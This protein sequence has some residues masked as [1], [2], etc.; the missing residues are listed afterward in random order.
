MR[1]YFLLLDA[2]RF[3]REIVSALAASW[4]ARSFQ[5]THALCQTVLADIEA[6]GFDPTHLSPDETVAGQIVRHGIAFDRDVWRLL[7]GEVLL[8]CAAEIPEMETTPRALGC[9]LGVTEIPSDRSREQ[10]HWIEQV[11][12][13]S[14][15]ICLGGGFYRPEQAGYNDR[16]DVTRLASL[17]A[18][19]RMEAWRPEQLRALPDLETDDDRAEELAYVREWF[20]SLRELYEK[21]REQ[22]QIIVCES[23]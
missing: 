7:V 20:P 19:V 17:L 4:F 11:H 6:S 12:Y 3:D 18:G 16:A 2:D 13:G 21:A 8:Y 22:R 15:D 5:P 10:F 14:R 1:L 23:L 9:L